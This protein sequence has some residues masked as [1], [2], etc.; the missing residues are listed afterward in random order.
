MGH[1][2]AL[3]AIASLQLSVQGPILAQRPS[4]VPSAPPQRVDVRFSL[5]PTQNVWT[6][7]LLDTKTGRIWQVQ[8]AISDSAFA[9]RLLVND[10]ALAPAGSARVGRFTL[11]ETQNIFNFLLLDQDDGRVWQVQWSNVD[12]NR[13]IVQ[14]LSER[15]P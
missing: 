13:G 10:V 5:V 8:Y 11:R 12:G 14:L 3:L 6:F 2:R 7:L 15:V 4:S 1:F 9:G